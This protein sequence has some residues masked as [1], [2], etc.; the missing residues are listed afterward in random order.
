LDEKPQNQFG[1]KKPQNQFGRKKPQN[2]FGL[3][4][5]AKSIWFEKNRKINLQRQSNLYFIQSGNAISGITAPLWIDY[6]L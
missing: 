5:T 1:R 2:Q 6:I 4:K 3:K